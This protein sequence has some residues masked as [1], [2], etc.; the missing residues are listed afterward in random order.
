MKQAR[1]TIGRLMM[2]VAG[3]AGELWLVQQSI[4][5]AIIAPGCVWMGWRLWQMC[6][7]QPRQAGWAVISIALIALIPLG[8]LDVYH[9]E[10][11]GRWL[12]TVV[13]C[14]AL[15]SLVAALVAS[16]RDFRHQEAGLR[17]AGWLGVVL[18]FALLPASMPVTN[19]PIRL[20]FLVSRPAL[21]GLADRVV[22]GAAVEFPRWAGA[23]QI[24]GVEAE[25]QPNSTVALLLGGSIRPTSLSRTTSANHGP[26]N[27][28]WF[29][30]DL[31]PAW[32]FGCQP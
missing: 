10:P 26:L 32:R 14:F 18:V 17:R 3:V 6:R 12:S 2:A 1:F 7:H 30:I 9:R 4:F 5:L 24:K 29:E 13:L 19:W 16:V 20:A 23:F 15:P 11:L 21:D 31:S 25:P 8:W 28:P 27:E 22:T